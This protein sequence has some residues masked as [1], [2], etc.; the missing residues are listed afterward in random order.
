M[1]SQEIQQSQKIILSQ[2]S[3]MSLKCLQ[4][5]PPELSNYI[6][7]LWLSN[8]LLE[9]EEIECHY[10]YSN[11]YVESDLSFEYEKE[12]ITNKNTDP[13]T[14]ISN[15]P[16]PGISF[17]D[18][19]ISQLRLMKNIPSDILAISMFLVGCLNSRGYLDCQISE[20][21]SEIGC[22]FFEME[23]ALFVL[24]SLDPAGVGARSL[25]ECLI[26]QL[27]QTNEFNEL[28]L[29]MIKFGLNL[30]SQ[31]KYDELAKI[32]G[33]S[34]KE[35]IKSGEIIKKLEPIPSRGFDSGKT[36]PYI[37]PE[38]TVFM[39]GNSLEISFNHS[40]LPIVK[41]NT[42]YVDAIRKDGNTAKDWLQKNLTEAK[43]L[44]SSIEAR[45]S[46]ILKIANAILIIQ[47]DF[48]FNNSPIKPMT[49]TQIAEEVGVSTS[50]VSRAVS[51][52]YLVFNSKLI[53]F[54]YF[55]T[56]S[57]IMPEGAEISSD[58]AKK[59]IS[60]LIKSEDKKAPL[61]DSV[62]QEALAEKGITIS[63]RTIT[64]YRL[65]LG[66]PAAKQRRQH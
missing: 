28:N 8:P 3:Q 54:K 34:K 61:S 49:M 51:E 38:L 48:F 15:I 59:E 62:I 52:K 43:S 6:R 45:S 29:H 60:L 18:Y 22:S 58:F 11:D 2:Y 1:L 9:I 4:M 26:L 47:R 24:Q 14:Y 33:C 42:E 27:A 53:P 16:A 65:A 40:F 31:K 21:S 55:F 44:I 56:S 7:E 20:L 39:S 19:L 63:R 17:E 5:T 66:I 41:I 10:D 36:S 23:Q 30:L 32:L 37:I 57:I 13:N 50:T 12:W 46:T 35:A 64:K 25:S